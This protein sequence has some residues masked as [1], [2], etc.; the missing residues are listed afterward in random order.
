MN[1]SERLEKFTEFRKLVEDGNLNTLGIAGTLGISK[2][3]VYNWRKKLRTERTQPVQQSISEKQTP[4]SFSRVVVSPAPVSAPASSIEIVIKNNIVI[5]IPD[6]S[7]STLQTILDS[8]SQ[9]GC[10]E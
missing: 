10:A 2:N 4:Q 7:P 3:T 8:I 1:V 9:W 5:R 6:H